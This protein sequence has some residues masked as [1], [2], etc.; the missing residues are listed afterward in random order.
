[1][2]HSAHGLF[3]QMLK[4][5]VE[6]KLVQAQV[7]RSVTKSQRTEPSTGHGCDVASGFDA[8]GMQRIFNLRIGMQ[9][10]QILILSFLENR[11]HQSFLHLRFTQQ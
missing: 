11:Q 3:H 4:S 6:Q 2:T 10:P 8:N 1:M 5:R 9:L 7:A